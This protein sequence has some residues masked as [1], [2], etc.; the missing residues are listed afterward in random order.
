MTG[1]L[2][3]PKEGIVQSTFVGSLR[4]QVEELLNSS[5]ELK[6]DFHKYL[7]LG[8]WPDG[9]SQD[10]RSILLSWFLQWYN[11]PASS[12]IRTAIDR[13]KPKRMSSSSIPLLRLSLPR[14]H[15]NVISEIDRCFT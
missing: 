11:V 15:I 10:K 4:K 8:K 6:D 5:Q 1:K 3:T 2:S 12:V 13:V 7:K 14:T 9:E